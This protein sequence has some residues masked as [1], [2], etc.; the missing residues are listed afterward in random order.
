AC[1]AR[2]CPTQNDRPAPVRT[3]ARTRGSA[4]TRA[5]V[6]RN[7]SFRAT[8]RLLPLSGRFNVMVATALSN[9]SSTQ[10]SST[11]SPAMAERYHPLLNDRLVIPVASSLP[12]NARPASRRGHPEVDAM[13]PRVGTAESGTSE[14]GLL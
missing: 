6:S 7:A 10:L 14:F 5:N 9:T 2:S 11:V 1:S 12:H 8:V 3:T 4:A 13:T